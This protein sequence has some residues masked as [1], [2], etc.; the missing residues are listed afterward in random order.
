M[1]D[2]NFKFKSNVTFYYQ[3]QTIVHLYKQIY[4][5][6]IVLHNNATNN[7]NHPNPSTIAT[8]KKNKTYNNKKETDVT[9]QNQA[10][11]QHVICLYLIYNFNH[12]KLL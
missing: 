9:L 6:K 10:V 3:V 11:L 7:K 5:L 1:I 12:D 8:E 2:L 4:N